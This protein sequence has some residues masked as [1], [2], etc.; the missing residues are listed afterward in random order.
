MK[1]NQKKQFDLYKATGKALK[2]SEKEVRRLMQEQDK[3]RAAWQ[4]EPQR[5]SEVINQKNLAI[6]DRDKKFEE[7]SKYLQEVKAERDRLMEVIR[8]FTSISITPMDSATT[9]RLTGSSSVGELVKPK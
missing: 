7:G 9:V 8:R 1:K 6:A 2:A 5:H 4:R 3:M